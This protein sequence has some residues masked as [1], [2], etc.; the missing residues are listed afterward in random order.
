MKD[1]YIYSL[2]SS[3][4]DPLTEL[5]GEFKRSLELENIIEFFTQLRRIWLE[6]N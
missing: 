6:D 2:T 4:K 1:N 3:P 5:V